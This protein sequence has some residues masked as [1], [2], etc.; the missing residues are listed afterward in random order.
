MS[1]RYTHLGGG[2]NAASESLEDKGFR[3]GSL[4]DAALNCRVTKYCQ[5]VGYGLV[6]NDEGVALG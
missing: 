1:H 6:C 5:K 3:R 2:K 4:E